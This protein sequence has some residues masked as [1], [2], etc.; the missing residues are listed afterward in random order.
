MEWITL[1][2]F[3]ATV[4]ATV[5]IVFFFKICIEVFRAYRLELDSERKYELKIISAVILGIIGLYFVTDIV[6]IAFFFNALKSI[7]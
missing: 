3:C 6:L 4:L 7:L 1:G 2:T 5:A